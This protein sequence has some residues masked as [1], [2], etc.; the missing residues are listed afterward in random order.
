[1]RVGDLVKFSNS[2]GWM[3]DIR[4]KIGV[5]VAINHPREGRGP[6]PRP[7][8]VWREWNCLINGELVEGFTL[9]LDDPAY[10][11]RYGVEVLSKVCNP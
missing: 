8:E 10:L 4:D 7:W 9:R 2:S 3:P 6:P 5:V 11:E 1:M